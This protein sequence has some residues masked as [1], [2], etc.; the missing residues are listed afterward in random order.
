VLRREIGGGD[1]RPS[2]Y[3]LN[4]CLVFDSAFV[5][6][7]RKAQ[8]FSKQ[9]DFAYIEFIRVSPISERYQGHHDRMGG[10]VWHNPKDSKVKLDYP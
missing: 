6:K 4:N 5:H 8:L 3:L 1:G 9:W 7:M 10:S 2:K